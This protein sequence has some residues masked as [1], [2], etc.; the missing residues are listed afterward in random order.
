MSEFLSFFQGVGVSSAKLKKSFWAVYENAIGFKKMID[1]RQ[2][3]VDAHMSVK[4][5]HIVVAETGSLQK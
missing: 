1:T 3:R 2:I 4:A 5:P